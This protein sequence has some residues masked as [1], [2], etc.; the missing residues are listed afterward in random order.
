MSWRFDALLFLGL[1]VCVLT[2]RVHAATLEARPATESRLTAQPGEMI[3]LC[4]RVHNPSDV[5]CT[6]SE[7]Y[8]LPADWRITAVE[9]TALALAPGGG[10]L[11]FAALV[12]PAHAQA[13]EY[14]ITGHWTAGGAPASA[15]CVVTVPTRERLEVALRRAA[16]MAVSGETYVVDL[17]ASNRGNAPLRVRPSAGAPHVF[18]VQFSPVE[19]TLAP[20]ETARLT[21]RVMTEAGLR[22]RTIVPVEFVLHGPTGLAARVTALTELFPAPALTR[23]DLWPARLETRLLR[24]PDGR[25]L[26]QAALGGTATFDGGRQFS[27]FLRSPGET[28]EGLFDEPELYR[29]DYRGPVWSWQAGNQ[30]YALSP[31]TTRAQFGSGAALSYAPG[32]NG[33]GGV[34][35]M[36]SRESASIGH[37]VGAFATFEATNALSVTVTAL[38]KTT[39]FA[40]A[41]AGE[42]T[43]TVAIGARYDRGKAFHGAAEVGYSPWHAGAEGSPAAARMEVGGRSRNGLSGEVLA[44]IYGDAYFGALRGAHV[45]AAS[46]LVPLTR[47]LDFRAEHRH[48]SYLEPYSVPGQRRLSNREAGQ[49]AGL[50]W[51][52]AETQFGLDGRRASRV[53][54]FSETATR[55]EESAVQYSAQTTLWRF[56]AAA[57]IEAGR[58]HV[59]G[60]LQYESSLRRAQ[61]SLLWAPGSRGN[62]AVNLSTGNDPYSPVAAR[63]R[64]LGLSGAVRFNSRWSASAHAGENLYD[65]REARRRSY[66]YLQTE[67][68]LPRQQTLGLKMAWNGLASRTARGPSIAFSFSR[69]LGLPGPSFSRR[70]SISGT[71]REAGSGAPVTRAVVVLNGAAAVTDAQGAFA[72]RNL[73]PG[74]YQLNIEP[75]SIGEDRMIR[76]TLPRPITLGQRERSVTS[77]SAEQAGRVTVEVVATAADWPGAAP[78]GVA[79]LTVT[80]RNVATD[81]ELR[82]LTDDSG[83]ALF[84]SV[85]PG[86]WRARLDQAALPPRY[87][88]QLPPEATRVTSGD[89]H[90]IALAMNYDAPSIRWLAANE[91]APAPPRRE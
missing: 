74:D 67:Y 3:T 14:P 25:V 29:F 5:P 36:R 19:L 47:G 17:L 79:G 63:T 37:Q 53:F 71:L 7:N 61:Y 54:G 16:T 65:A 50:A 48:Q 89:A 20:G 78:A 46:T 56:V 2:G 81:A 73:P 82:E 90:T 42:A 28:G 8:D 55:Q 80:L 68:Q 43:G 85:P 24:R 60:P 21:A 59:S 72:F 34:L 77:L 88:L 13:G 86:S 27:Y 10:A 38:E 1:A 87:R 45:V 52:W 31:L 84:R 51:R 41:F 75:S 12:V 64:A 66:A 30:A 22:Q 62:L 70:G 18:E 11:R 58:L 83:R 23:E 69:P 76:E 4:W 9:K 91:P 15:V 57:S 33:S 39:G 44:E 32:G 35:V 49:S 40:Q 6:V 26:P